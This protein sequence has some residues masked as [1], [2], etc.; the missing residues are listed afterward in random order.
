ME[1][2]QFGILNGELQIN[3]GSI[4]E[5]MIAQRLRCNGFHLDYFDGKDR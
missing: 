2:V 5:N 1:N 4:L 3:M